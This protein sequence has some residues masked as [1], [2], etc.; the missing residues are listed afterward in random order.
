MDGG[1]L[2]VRTPILWAI[3]GAGAVTVVPRALPLV[4]LSRVPLPRP[5]V[6]WLGFVPVAVLAGLLAQ[7][8]AMPDGRLS[9]PPGNLA[10]LAVLPTLLVAVRTRSLAGTVA[11]G[12]AAMALLRWC[13][14]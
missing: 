3:I 6:R 1:W 5:F 2:D 9:L 7:S 10:V 8:V 4:L 11:A 13:I 12:I 14:G